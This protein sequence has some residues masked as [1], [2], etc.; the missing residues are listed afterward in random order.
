MVSE[1]QALF[2]SGRLGEAIAAQTAAVRAAPGEVDKRW[3]LA[4][5]LCFAG[6]RERADR[7]LDIIGSQTAATQEVIAFR[8]LLRAEEI[9]HQVLFEGRAPQIVGARA[10]SLQD[11]LEALLLLRSGEPGAAAARLAAHLHS[12]PPVA[13]RH[14]GV[15]FSEFRDLDDVLATVVEVIG[16]DGGYRWVAVADIVRLELLPLRRPRDL[17]WRPAQIAV[18]DGPAGAVWLPCLYAADRPVA[19]DAI[20]LGRRTDWQEGEEGLVRGS[21]QRIF[22]VGEKDVPIHELGMIEF[23]RVADGE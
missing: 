15:A 12:A 18:V 17:I 21:G 23:A 6:E 16:G 20:A 1:A 14:D 2:R 10:A 5:L 8:L 4:E 22:L 11:V 3:F 7:M 9:R 13:G 19:D